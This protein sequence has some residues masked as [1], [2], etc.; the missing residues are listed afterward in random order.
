MSDEPFPTIE[1]ALGTIMLRVMSETMNSNTD[2]ER[3]AK[4]EG[5]RNS[6]VA[7]WP[8]EIKTARERTVWAPGENGGVRALYRAG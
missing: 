5:V 3:M 6:I 2:K 4:L 7:L 8:D 1:A